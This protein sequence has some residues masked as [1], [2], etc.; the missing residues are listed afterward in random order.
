M[1]N[2][3]PGAHPLEPA[4]L[5]A[6]EEGDRP[7]TERL[8]QYVWRPPGRAWWTLFG[9]GLLGS[10]L[11]VLGITATL[12]YGIGTWGNNIPVAWAF[13]IINFVWWIEIAHAGTLISA[14]LLLFIQKWRN[15]INR[16]A[17]TMT[18]IA[19]LCAGIFPILHLGRPWYAFWLIPYPSTLGVW[20]QF[21]SPLVWDVFA[22]G[23]YL[24][25]S[26]LFWYTGLVPDL[27]AARDLSARRW[28]RIL[29]GVFAIGWRGSTRH[30]RHHRVAYLMFAGLITP[31][32]ITVMSVI[33]FDFTAGILAGWHSTI[34]PP[35]FVAGAILSGFAM[36]A[37][38]LIP[39]RRF[40]HLEAVITPRHL[41]NM[42]RV[43]LVTSL[44]TFYSYI[45]EYF[46]AWYGG[47]PFEIAV[48]VNQAAGFYRSLW[49]GTVF[50]NSLV[51][52][53]FWSARMRRSPWLLWTA[54]L[55]INIGMWTE[56][57]MI[58]V[59]PL[60]RDYLP[61]SWRTYAPTYVD[62]SLLT[63]TLCF[64]LTCYLLFLK[65]LPAVP[66]G[67]VKELQHERPL[68]RTGTS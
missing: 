49:W 42:A 25:V 24:I 67:D 11:L 19:V 47:N 23:T 68:R 14:V 43:I 60:H 30:W 56:R 9:I 29:Y 10:V 6:G 5:L 15:S 12:L 53:L 44:F 48:E 39:V 28:Q 63:G 8:L 62:W 18:V 54:S 17:E 40:L 4:P 20:P 64:F 50:C 38:L 7:L 22:V 27:A 45:M 41:D 32:V 13:A 33:S 34:F 3:A 52:Q 57:F 36:V 16:F 1:S 37:T 35:Y 61:S 31:L 26:T 65:L 46:M 55:L 51:P 66:I 2:Q 21:R 59:N 58:V